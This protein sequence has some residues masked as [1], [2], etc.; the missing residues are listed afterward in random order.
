MV[1]LVSNSGIEQKMEGFQQPPFMDEIA[2]VLEKVHLEPMPLAS[3]LDDE[4]GDE[5]PWLRVQQQG[6]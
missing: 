1:A 4:V 5:C 6:W 2:Y 3:L